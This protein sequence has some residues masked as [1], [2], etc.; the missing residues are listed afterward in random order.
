MISSRPCILRLYLLVIT[1][2][3]L[4]VHIYITMFLNPTFYKF[5]MSMPVSLPIFITIPLFVHIR[6]GLCT[7]SGVRASRATHALCTTN[8]R[9]THGVRFNA[10]ENLLPKLCKLRDANAPRIAHVPRIA[11]ALRVVLVHGHATIT[12]VLEPCVPWCVW[13]RC[14]MPLCAQA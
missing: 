4:C 8:L 12:H 9:F 11:H 6:L 3:F 2:L 5:N 7:S 14:S 13:A 10:P 1:S